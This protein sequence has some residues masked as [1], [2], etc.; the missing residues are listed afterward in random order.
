MENEEQKL[1]AWLSSCTIEGAAQEL[2]MRDKT[3]ENWALWRAA[4]TEMGRFFSVLNA[5][6]YSNFVR[7]YRSKE[8]QEAS[9]DE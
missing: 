9:N 7:M 8:V 5:H 2:W 1:T 3:E 6:K 4:N